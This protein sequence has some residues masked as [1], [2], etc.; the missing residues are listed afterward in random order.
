MDCTSG[1]VCYEYSLLLALNPKLVLYQPSVC[2]SL[3][4]KLRRAINESYVSEGIEDKKY[5]LLHDLA[6]RNTQHSTLPLSTPY[7]L[8]DDP[9]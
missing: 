1:M 3:Y 4:V 6:S 8:V 9:Y 7:V 5:I 2:L